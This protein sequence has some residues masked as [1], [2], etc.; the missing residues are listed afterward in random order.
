MK[1][2]DRFTLITNVSSRAC[3]FNF[4]LFDNLYILTK[5]MNVSVEHKGGKN[6]ALVL[7]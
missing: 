6:P 2:T 5:V 4:W 3:Y 1:D 7:W